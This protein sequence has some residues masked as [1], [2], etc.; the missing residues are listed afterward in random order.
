MSEAGA[1]FVLVTFMQAPKH[2]GQDQWKPVKNDA[3]HQLNNNSL[4]CGGSHHTP[5]PALV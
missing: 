5:T 3:Y 2:I 4:I 1:C